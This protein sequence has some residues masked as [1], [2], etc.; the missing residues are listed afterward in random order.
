MKLTVFFFSAAA[1]KIILAA[2]I[3]YRNKTQ[4]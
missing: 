2:V 3:G 1:A 4:E